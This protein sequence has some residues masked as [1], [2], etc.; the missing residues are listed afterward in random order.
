MDISKMN[1]AVQFVLSE[2]DEIISQKKKV[3][4]KEESV[5]VS[6]KIH[7]EAIYT[8]LEAEKAP[9]LPDLE[10]IRQ[11]I[12]NNEYHIDYEKLAERMLELEKLWL[13]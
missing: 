13:E 11:R 4:K 6:E 2:S 12:S 9:E 5:I 7:E 3:K 8:L 1:Q 10:M